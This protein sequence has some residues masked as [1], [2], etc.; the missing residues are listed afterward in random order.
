MLE[1]RYDYEEAIKFFEKASE[2]YVLDNTPTSANQ[3]LIKASD[4]R[5]LTRDYANSLPK[6]I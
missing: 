6:A 4:L 3:I 1:E 2:L 5:I